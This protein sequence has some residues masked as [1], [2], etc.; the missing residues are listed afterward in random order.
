METFEIV[1]RAE[2]PTAVIHEKVPMKELPQFFSRAL[3]EVYGAVQ[4]QGLTPAGPPFALYFGMPGETVEVEAGFP[5]PHA[6]KDAGAVHTGKLPGGK[7]VHGLHTGPYDT[8]SKTYGELTEWTKEHHL[9]PHDQVWEVYL[10]DPQKE[11]DPKKW[12]TEIF[13]PVD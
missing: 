8:M 7:C 2:Q 10:S 1:N 4:A 5:V 12:K 3:G 13:W 6:L 11:P 9:T